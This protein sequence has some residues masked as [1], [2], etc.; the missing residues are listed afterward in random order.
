MI[1]ISRYRWGIVAAS[2]LPLVLIFTLSSTAFA[3]VTA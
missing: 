1:V 3:S 2:L